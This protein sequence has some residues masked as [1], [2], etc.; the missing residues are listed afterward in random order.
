M[1]D[2]GVF[3]IVVEVEGYTVPMKSSMNNLNKITAEKVTK[4]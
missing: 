2:S 4:N 3:S 1:L